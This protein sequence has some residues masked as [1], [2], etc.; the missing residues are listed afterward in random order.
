[1]MPCDWIG[2]VTIRSDTRC[3]TSTNGMI[4]R[5]PGSRTPTHPAQPEQH[6]PLVLLDD[7]HRKRDQDQQRNDDDD[8]NQDFHQRAPVRW[9]RLQK[10]ATCSLQT[11]M[12]PAARGIEV[13]KVPGDQA[14]VIRQAR[15]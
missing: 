9:I 12:G 8:N 2:I 11:T 7:P 4:N 3:R 6:P 10:R 14:I 15:I 13:P 5:S 1:M